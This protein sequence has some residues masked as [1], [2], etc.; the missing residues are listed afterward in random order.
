MLIYCINGSRTREA[1]PV[2][3]ANGIDNL[4]H[5]EGAF[6]QWIK[7]R[8]PFEKGGVKKTGW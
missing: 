8:R 4:Y 1:E 7:D 6:Q 2:L 3:Y 5:L